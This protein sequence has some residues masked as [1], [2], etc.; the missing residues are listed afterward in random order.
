[1][2][3]KISRSITA[4]INRKRLRDKKIYDGCQMFQVIYTRITW[5]EFN[6]KRIFKMCSSI[7]QGF[8]RNKVTLANKNKRNIWNETRF[9]KLDDTLDGVVFHYKDKIRA[10]PLSST[11]TI[12]LN[13]ITQSSGTQ[14]AQLIIGNDVYFETRWALGLENQSN[15]SSL[16]QDHIEMRENGYYNSPKLLSCTLYAQKHD[17]SVGGFAWKQFRK[18]KTEKS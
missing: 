6:A 17:R 12:R 11:N 16:D 18:T 8:R 13:S 10:L 3:V 1:M 7:W 5:Y 9:R 14:N 2:R 4:S 15:M